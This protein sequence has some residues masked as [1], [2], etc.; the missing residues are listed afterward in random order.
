MINLKYYIQEKYLIDLDFNPEVISTPDEVYF[1]VFVNWLK[2]EFEFTNKEVEEFKNNLL[3]KTT[4]DDTNEFTIISYKKWGTKEDQID[5]VVKNFKKLMN[6]DDR[7][8]AYHGNYKIYYFKFRSN[9]ALFVLFIADNTKV[10][11]TYL[12]NAIL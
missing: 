2:Q 8:I 5:V 9:V 1:E 4:F 10:L 6:I 3:E 7:I 11:H 12:L